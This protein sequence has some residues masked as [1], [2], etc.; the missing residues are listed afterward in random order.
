[1]LSCTPRKAKPP[2]W[3]CEPNQSTGKQFSVVCA[4][5]STL[6]HTVLQFAVLRCAGAALSS[7]A[8]CCAALCCAENELFCRDGH[9]RLLG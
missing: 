2:G 4:A 8:L 9:G 6:D 1:M 5:G 7:A 3:L